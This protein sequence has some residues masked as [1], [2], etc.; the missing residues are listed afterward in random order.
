MSDRSAKVAQVQAWLDGLHSTIDEQNKADETV[1][2]GA[3]TV[4][5]PDELAP[6]PPGARPLSKEEMA[7]RKEKEHQDQLERQAEKH[8]DYQERTEYGKKLR[9]EKERLAEEERQRK[10][11]ERRKSDIQ[12]ASDRAVQIGQSLLATGSRLWRT[13]RD[14][15]STLPTPG[16]IWVPLAILLLFFFVLFPVNGHTRIMWLWMTITGNAAIGGALPHPTAVAPT[17]QVPGQNVQAQLTA[18]SSSGGQTVVST[19]QN[20]Q[21]PQAGYASL[22]Q[23]LS[24]F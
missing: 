21:V 1:D 18:F 16:D 9:A 22:M 7:V 15:L 5:P 11:E 14:K 12:K 24:Q 6:A 4:F 23:S 8:R 20:G 3:D 17:P 10:L 13:S 19:P 2:L